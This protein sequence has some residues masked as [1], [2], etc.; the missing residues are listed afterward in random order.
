MIFRLPVAAIPGLDMTTMSMFDSLVLFALKHSRTSRFT[1]LRP[2]APP[3]DLTEMA[4]PSRLSVHRVLRAS[5]VNNRS[6]ERTGFRN[7]RSK[8]CFV[9]RR[10]ACP[11]R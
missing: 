5:T 3:A 1:R 8:S 6:E 9:R 2:A 7:T 4:S 11:K 10:L